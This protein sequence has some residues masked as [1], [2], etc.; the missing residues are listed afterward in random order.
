MCLYYKDKGTFQARLS[1]L[2]VVVAVLVVVKAVATTMQFCLYINEHPSGP[3]MLKFNYNRNLYIF[4]MN[5][6]PI[7]TNP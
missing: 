2:R 3:Y 1:L 7:N 4:L 6:T 5:L